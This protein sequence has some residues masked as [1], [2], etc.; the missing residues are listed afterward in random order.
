VNDAYNANPESMAAA[1]KAARWIAADRQ[2]IAVLG[3]M[4]ELGAISTEAHERVGEL[5][6]RLRI[7]RLITVGH[8]AK[9]IATAAVREGVPPDDV[10]NYDDRDAVLAD[11]RAHATNGDVVLIKAS[12]VAGLEQ[13]AEALR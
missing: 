13:L 11:L 7:D 8:E 3:H 5:A 6:A 1:L 10:V 12:R 9:T 2:L 4:A